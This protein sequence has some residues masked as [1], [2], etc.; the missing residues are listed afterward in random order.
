MKYLAKAKYNY[1]SKLP[2]NNPKLW[3]HFSLI[4]DLCQLLIYKELKSGYSDV[5]LN[6]F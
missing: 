2:W 1:L 6:N 3:E 5:L 4:M